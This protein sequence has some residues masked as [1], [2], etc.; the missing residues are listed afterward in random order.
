MASDPSNE[1]RDDTVDAS[2]KILPRPG[3]PWVYGLIEKPNLNTASVAEISSGLVPKKLA[4]TLACM[5]DQRP[6][7]NW[8]AVRAVYGVGP[9]RFKD[10]QCRF[11]LRV[12]EP[13]DKPDDEPDDKPDDKPGENVEQKKSCC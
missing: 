3:D 2:P 12:D 9:A 5:A 1:A 7:A 6:F 11:V 8:D 4:S 13:D 10:L